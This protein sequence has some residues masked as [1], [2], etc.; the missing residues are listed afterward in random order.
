[1]DSLTTPRSVAFQMA[2]KMGVRAGKRRVFIDAE[3][4]TDVEY[5]KKQIRMLA[6]IARKQGEAIGIGHARIWTVQALREELPVLEKEGFRFVYA[7]QV[8]R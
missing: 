7:S 6:D 5:I 8:V 2:R 4:Y 3:N 1:M